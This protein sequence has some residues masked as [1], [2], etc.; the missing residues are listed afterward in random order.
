MSLHR[1]ALIAYATVLM[2]IFVG[3]IVRGTG[4]GLGC[5]D[6]PFCYGRLVPP[7][8]ADQID[9]TK[10]DLEKFRRK[11]AQHGQDPASITA[12]SIRAEFNPTHT[13]IEYINRLS[14]TPVGLS[15]L[16]LV[17]VAFRQ[18][19]QLPTVHL[20]AWFSLWI[21]LFNAWLGA[22]VVYS[23]LKPG[24]ITLHMA[25]AIVL[26]CVLVFIAWRTSQSSSSSYSPS[27]SPYKL[28]LLLFLCVILEGILGS[29]V[30]EMTDL[31]AKTHQGQP[32]SAWVAEL[33]QSWVYLTHRSA[34]WLILGLGTAFYIKNT[35]RT[36]L[37]KS[38]LGI[39]LAQM[40]LGIILAHV[41]IVPTAQILH[42]GLS[43]L[44]VSGL[45]LWLLDHLDHH[46]LAVRSK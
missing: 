20:A 9:F 29:Q 23:G 25:L 44:L 16:A 46:Y 5:P 33:E 27:S 4:S 1:L 31:L 42:I 32:R 13:W 38:I 15:V 22:K 14:S 7:T 6:W 34:S 43:A 17:I 18:R 41:G 30:R 40:V 10:L 12:E 3:A 2:L 21:V 35:P 37:E 26:L 36:W 8:T 19:K 11:A 24:I 45:F 39:I 28:A